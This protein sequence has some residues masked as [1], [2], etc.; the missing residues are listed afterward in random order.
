MSP[1]VPSEYVGRRHKIPRYPAVYPSEFKYDEWEG[2]W[3]CGL[4]LIIAPILTIVLFVILGIVGTFSWGLLFLTFIGVEI[5]LGGITALAVV[6]SENE[7]KKKYYER[8]CNRLLKEASE[9][10]DVNNGWYDYLTTYDILSE[11]EFVPRNSLTSFEIIGRRG[12]EI[13]VACQ[14]YEYATAFYGLLIDVTDSERARTC[15]AL[16]HQRI[17]RETDSEASKTGLMKI[18]AFIT[19]IFLVLVIIGWAGWFFHQNKEAQPVGA[20]NRQG[21]ELLQNARGS[22]QRVSHELENNVEPSIARLDQDRKNL[23]LKL[24]GMGVRES[25]DIKGNYKGAVLAKELAEVVQY[26]DGLNEKKEAYLQS[27]FELGVLIRRLKRQEIAL[28]AGLSQEEIKQVDISLRTIDAR[29]SEIGE[30]DP[31]EIETV[32]EQ[33]L[34]G[35]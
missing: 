19:L 10:I 8:H 24:R 12:A 18:L 7:E 11:I 28:D 2:E 27:K 13:A 1:S 32:L 17:N 4:H 20:E 3:I 16:L 30:N 9:A 29:L 25:E 15:L 33:E 34:V 31:I 6:S 35:H 22:L 26:L 5:V 14:D 21:Q 23:V